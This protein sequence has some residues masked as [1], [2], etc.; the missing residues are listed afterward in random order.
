MRIQDTKNALRAK[1]Q[2]LSAM[3]TGM[4]TELASAAAK[5][6]VRHHLSVVYAS[7]MAA[8]LPAIGQ[9]AEASGG[10]IVVGGTAKDFHNHLKFKEL[11]CVRFFGCWRFA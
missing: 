10:F 11:S 9:D 8:D 5:L 1:E 7:P 3:E 6:A 2:E 4:T